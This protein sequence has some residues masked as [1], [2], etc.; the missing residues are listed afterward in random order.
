[1]FC[2]F[3]C[4]QRFSIAIKERVCAYINTRV[5]AQKQRSTSA[6]VIQCFSN[7]NSISWK[8]S[9]ETAGGG[10][11]NRV[12]LCN[13]KR[14]QI[15]WRLLWMQRKK[16]KQWKPCACSREKGEKAQCLLF[17]LRKWTADQHSSNWK[18]SRPK[19]WQSCVLFIYTILLQL[20]SCCWCYSSACN[21]DIRVFFLS[22]TKPRK[23]YTSMLREQEL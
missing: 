11:F 13:R 12:F 20:K 8:S 15:H 21:S 16:N 6:I 19:K 2:V 4:I 22:K 14:N 23:K 10:G 17:V 5:D 7:G 18:L 3:V 1:M 9:K